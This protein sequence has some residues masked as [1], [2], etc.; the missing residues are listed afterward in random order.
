MVIQNGVNLMNWN[1]VTI[2]QLENI[3]LALPLF[4]LHHAK[5]NA[6]LDT[7]FH[8]AMI[9]IMPAKHTLL[10]ARLQQYRPKL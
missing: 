8:G 5:N 4:L 2:T 3:V 10:K 6:F 7:L 9:N 1:H